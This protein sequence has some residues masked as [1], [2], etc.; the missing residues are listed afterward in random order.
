M[1]YICYLAGAT[2]KTVNV[3]GN[4][5]IAEHREEPLPPSSSSPK[6]LSTTTKPTQEGLCLSTGCG[7]TNWWR[8]IESLAPHSKASRCA[9]ARAPRLSEPAADREL[10]VISPL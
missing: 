7:H 2:V 1:Y 4:A 5:A 6:R 8:S 3:N 10:R 9:F